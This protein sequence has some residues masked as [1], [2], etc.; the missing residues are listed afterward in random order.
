MPI[1]EMMSGSFFFLNSEYYVNVILNHCNYIMSL[2]KMAILQLVPT[3][4]F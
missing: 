1:D 4:N 3:T 2:V